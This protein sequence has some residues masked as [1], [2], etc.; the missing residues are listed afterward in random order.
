MVLNLI[1]KL[2]ELLNCLL[3]MSFAIGAEK[4]LG[5]RDFFSS[6]PN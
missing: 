6:G 3:N 4:E 1:A 5:P 2:L